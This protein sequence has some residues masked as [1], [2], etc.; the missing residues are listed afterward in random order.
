M[1]DW[2]RVR[3]AKADKAKAGGSEGGK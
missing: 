3:E 2:I 1:H